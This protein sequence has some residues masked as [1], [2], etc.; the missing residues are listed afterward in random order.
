MSR[1][2]QEATAA[3]VVADTSGTGSTIFCGDGSKLYDV[4][5]TLTPIFVC[6]NWTTPINGY[7]DID[8]NFSLYDC[9]VVRGTSTTHCC[10]QSAGVMVV[11]SNQCID[12]CLC[13]TCYCK[14][15]LWYMHKYSGC[16]CNSSTGQGCLCT[17]TMGCWNRVGYWE[18]MFKQG[19][20]TY[21]CECSCTSQTIDVGIYFTSFSSSTRKDVML[22]IGC[23][24]FYPGFWPTTQVSTMA[25]LPDKAFCKFVIRGSNF[26]CFTPLVCCTCQ[27]D[28]A[29]FGVWGSLRSNPTVSGKSSAYK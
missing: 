26:N 3:G 1:F 8:V 20:G 6:C 15:N 7:V 4:R 12:S 28:G 9:I 27:V 19:R 23:R 25:Q 2:V 21:G 5:G 24:C 29:F 11:P 13:A 22:S 18:F 10:N 14:C 17:G 16:N